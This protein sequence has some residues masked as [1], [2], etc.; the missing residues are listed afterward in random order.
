[1]L[2]EL[3][4]SAML[5]GPIWGGDVAETP[6]QRRE[7]YSTVAEAIAEVA[8]ETK[9]PKRT[10]SILI[11][12]GENETTWSRYVLEGRCKDGPPGMR[13]DYDP[14]TGRVRARGPFQVWRW[15]KKAW[16]AKDGSY[17]SLVEGARCALSF[18]HRG[19]TRCKHWPGTFA[20]YRG[21]PCSAG[22][23]TGDNYKGQKYAKSMSLAGQRLRAL[24]KERSES[25]HAYL[26]ENYGYTN[27]EVSSLEDQGDNR[28]TP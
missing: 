16:S 14:K 6:E 18:V 1:M 26:R 10:A 20:A 21:Q 25:F 5:S 28:A 11:A 23:K 24:E 8:I 4:L 13:C 17:E 15:C 9:D 27:E 2:E 19:L 12:L 3:I 22:S 7:L